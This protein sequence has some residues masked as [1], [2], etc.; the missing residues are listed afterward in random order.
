MSAVKDDLLDNSKHTK[1]IE[2]TLENNIIP[3]LQNIESC[4]TDTY[5]RYSNGVEKI[6]SL[7]EDVGIMRKVIMEHSEKLKKILQVQTLL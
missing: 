3:R 6:D 7:Q 1:N 5:K 4:Y 2:I